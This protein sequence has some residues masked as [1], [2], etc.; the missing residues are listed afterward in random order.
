MFRGRRD[1]C[2]DGIWGCLREKAAYGL[3]LRR[4]RVHE[5]W[6]QAVQVEGEVEIKMWMLGRAACVQGVTTQRMHL[7][8]LGS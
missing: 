1:G 8:S 4:M 7:K 5:A 3:D 6:G 2:Q